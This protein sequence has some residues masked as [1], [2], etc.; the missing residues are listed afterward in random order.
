MKWWKIA[1]L[2]LLSTLCVTSTLAVLSFMDSI[3]PLEWYV[4]IAI[5]FGLFVGYFVLVK[6]AGVATLTRSQ[7]SALVLILVA[8]PIFGYAIVGL[9]I[10]STYWYQSMNVEMICQDGTPVLFSMY[11]NFSAVGSFSAENPVHVNVFINNVNISDL[12]THLGA[13]SLTNAYNLQESHIVG[14]TP[15]YGYVTLYPSENGTYVANGNL[16]WHQSETCYVIPLPPF[17]GTIISLNLAKLQLGGNPVLYVSP[18][19]DTLSFRSNYTLEQLTY[20]AVGFSV[21]ML[22][23]I[24]SALIPE[25]PVKQQNPQNPPQG[26][27]YHKQHRK[28]H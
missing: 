27:P 26:E 28:G 19:S 5:A 18:V 2:I 13:I 1:I 22:Q 3:A 23:P 25:E 20:A 16:I 14:A 9:K 15:A 21:I 12:T 11:F 7:T 17:T 6:F 8:L 10:P 24:L 4:K